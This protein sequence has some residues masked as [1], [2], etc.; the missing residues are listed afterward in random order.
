MACLI[1]APDAGGKGCVSFTTQER[2]RLINGNPALREAVTALKSRYLVGLHHN[3][4]DHDFVYDPLFDFSMAGEGDLK[5]RS[6]EQHPQVPID[7][8]NF[9]PDCFAPRED[10]EKFWDV[11]NVARAVNFKGIPEFLDAIRAIYDSGRMIRVL[12]LCPVPPA[13]PSGTTL[14]DIRERYEEMFT[15]EER[16]Y[17]TLITMEWDYPFPLDLESLS[18]FYRASRVYVH[19]APQERRCRIA[20]YAWASGMPVVARA[21]VA[22]ILPISERREPFWFGFDTDSNMPAA[23]LA[24][25]DSAISANR[26]ND[27]WSAVL[28]EFHASQSAFRL[29][30]W[31]DAFARKGGFKMSAQPINPSHM[32]I[33][34]GRHHEVSFGANCLPQKLSNFCSMLM[35]S[36]ELELNQHAAK[37]DP[38]L[39]MARLPNAVRP[40]PQKVH[41]R[42]NQLTLSLVKLQKLFARVLG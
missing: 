21:N 38:E 36:S 1:K 10:T 27:S 3:W 16:R 7:A 20:A 37:A 41:S 39:E 33:R 13:D 35:E 23:V 25:V 22:S 17:F 9:A 19:A 11:L 6:G 15:P 29:E 28:N 2:D 5:A 30:E 8:C 26:G 32:D 42:S 12:Y 14:H 34:L 18:F 24:A 4:H 40:A 31:L